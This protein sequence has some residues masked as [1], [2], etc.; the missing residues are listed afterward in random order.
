MS[1]STSLSGSSFI[2]SKNH[3]ISQVERDLKGSS[4]PTPF[5]SQDCLKL[6][7]M[8][9]SIIQVINR[10]CSSWLLLKFICFNYKVL[11]VFR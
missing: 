5:S 7:N 1:F 6:N 8:T 10:S 9:K 4:S 2:E 3:R 11:I